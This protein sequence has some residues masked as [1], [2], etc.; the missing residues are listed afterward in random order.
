MMNQLNSICKEIQRILISRDETLSTAESCT[1]GRMA[2]AITAIAGS[3]AYFQG[4]LVA[5]QNEV[6]MELLHINPKTIDRCDVV[7]REVVCEM[8]RG[9][10]TLFGTTYAIASS[11]YAGPGGGSDKVAQGTI[12]L[13]CGSPDNIRTCCMTEDH[14]RI[15]N[16]ENAT[17]TALSS[18]LDYLKEHEFT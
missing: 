9:A 3:S 15:A 7:S 16:V 14:G 2:A 8:V 11:G 13:A 5:Y 1:G 17:L 4:A 18:F 10:C 6:K 12:W